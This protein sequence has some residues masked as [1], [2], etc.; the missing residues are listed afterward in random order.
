MRE[1]KKH[2]ES[3]KSLT[4]DLL[5]FLGD[6]CSVHNAD[7]RCL[8]EGTKL[9]RRPDNWKISGARHT[10]SSAKVVRRNGEHNIDWHHGMYYF[11]HS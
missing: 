4:I 2:F 11:P 6:A 1:P 3:D 10:T 8:G 5:L 7:V 9:G